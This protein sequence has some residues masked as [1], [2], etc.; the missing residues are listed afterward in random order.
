MVADAD[1]PFGAGASPTTVSPQSLFLNDANLSAPNSSVLSALTSPSLA[2]DSPLWASD[3]DFSPN[4]EVVDLDATVPDWYPLFAAS[5]ADIASPLPPGNASPAVPNAACLSQR[6]EASSFN[7]SRPVR[8]NSSI[9]GVAPRNRNKPLPPM[10]VE[11]SSDVVAMKRARNT[12]AA[13]KSRE[14]KAQRMEDLEL[15]IARLTAERDYW[16]AMA[17]SR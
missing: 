11:D 8:R 2:N 1:L 5:G 6:R 9:A 7:S 10:V 3:F 12:L 15:E 4:F 13:R 17:E 16:K 14:R